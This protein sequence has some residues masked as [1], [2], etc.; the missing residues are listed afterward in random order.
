M[1]NH[2]SFILLI[3]C[4]GISPTLAQK[5]KS[6]EGKESLKTYTIRDAEQLMKKDRAAAITILADIIEEAKNTEDLKALYDANILLGNINSSAGF[7]QLAAE[8]Y[9]QAIGIE[10]SLSPKPKLTAA[11]YLADV[12]LSTNDPRTL[13]GFQM[14]IDNTSDIEQKYRCQ[15][16]LALSYLNEEKTEEGLKILSELESIYKQSN[17]P[18]LA[19]IQARIAQVELARN[20]IELAQQNLNNAYSNYKTSPASDYDIIQESKADVLE[21]TEDLEE[22][23]SILKTNVDLNVAKPEIAVPEQI[24]LA[25]AYLKNNEV[26]KAK[27]TIN[28]AKKIIDKVD[29]SKT[30][31]KLYKKASETYAAQGN[32]EE[33]LK[34][35]TAYQ[36][37]QS[38][39][40][41]EKEAEVNEQLAILS[42][43]KDIEISEKT[44]DS[45]QKLSASEA[46]RSKIQGYI[47]VLLCLLLLTAIIGGYTIWRNLKAKNIANKKLQLQSLRAQMNPHFIFNALNSVNEY[48]ATQDERRANRYLSDFSQLMR[49]VLEVNQKETI[50][51][52]DE[53]QLSKLYLKLEQDRFQDKFEYLTEIDPEVEQSDLQIPPLLLQPYLENAIWHGLRYRTKKGTLQLIMKELDEHLQ[54]T[55]MDNGIG[56][57]QSQALKTKHQKIHKSTG[58]ENTRSRMEI[59]EGLYGN[60]YEIQIE[61]AY[62]DPD[63][64]GT[65]VTILISK[66]AV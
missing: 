56:R 66:K 46:S 40:L 19:R 2:I 30:K 43:Q 9:Q 7:S 16:G 17:N 8:R 53:I 65:K 26:D 1:L 35:Y 18:S 27:A 6:S 11:E 5:K 48:I 20:N 25:E 31:A 58:M 42:S 3:L 24:E 50:P 12:Y 52:Q 55:M 37:V 29:D 15:E 44:Y 33:A 36:N 39:L 54:I 13:K 28:K 21:E 51:L 38:K 23:I 63:Y 32:Y 57:A 47:I 62:D 14:C 61:D 22:E 59:V 45:R 41:K 64:P 49:S 10:G 4:F 34:E 60:R